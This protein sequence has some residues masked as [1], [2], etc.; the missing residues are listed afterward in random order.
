MGDELLQNGDSYIFINNYNMYVE[1]LANLHNI[2]GEANRHY[3]P[4]MVT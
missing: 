1:H 3:L 2:I 4:S